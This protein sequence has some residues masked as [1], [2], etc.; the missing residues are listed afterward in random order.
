MATDLENVN[1][2]DAEQGNAEERGEGC[3]NCVWRTSS[4]ALGES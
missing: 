2:D 1:D 4:E 3:V